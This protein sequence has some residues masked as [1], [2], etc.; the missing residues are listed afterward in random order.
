MT[1]IDSVISKT[2][3]PVLLSTVLPLVPTAAQQLSQTLAAHETIFLIG[4]V[5][6]NVIPQVSAFLERISR[7]PDL[8]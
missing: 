2:L 6:Y 5:E 8:G 4:S 3:F 1:R 7:D